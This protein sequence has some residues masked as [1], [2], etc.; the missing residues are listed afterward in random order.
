MGSDISQE[1]SVV[2]L[3]HKVEVVLLEHK[4]LARAFTFFRLQSSVGIGKKVGT[5]VVVK[6]CN[7]I[8]KT[9]RQQL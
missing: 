8:Q 9:A 3:P 6:F 7:S 4:E 1:M 5:S 2:G